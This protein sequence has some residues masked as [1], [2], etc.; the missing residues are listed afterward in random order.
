MLELVVNAKCEG[1]LRCGHDGCV[2]R[3]RV[4]SNGRVCTP[5]KGATN[6]AT[7]PGPASMRDGD[8]P[9]THGCPAKPSMMN[10]ICSHIYGCPRK[11]RG[12]AAR[13]NL[14]RGSEG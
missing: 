11:V 7:T 12:D 1:R 5:G 2:F 9:A 3:D 14:R 10:G 4:L 13:C 6:A 8:V